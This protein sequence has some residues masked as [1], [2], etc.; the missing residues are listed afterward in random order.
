MNMV[1]GYSAIGND[2]LRRAWYLTDRNWGLLRNTREASLSQ[3]VLCSSLGEVYCNGMAFSVVGLGTSVPN[4][5]FQA[6]SAAIDLWINKD[7]LEILEQLECKTEHSKTLVVSSIIC[8]NSQ[9]CTTPDADLKIQ[10]SEVF[11]NPKEIPISTMPATLEFKCLNPIAKWT[12]FSGS[13]LDRTL[14]SAEVV[15]SGKL[16]RGD[17]CDNQNA[18]IEAV[19]YQALVASK[20]QEI[21]ESYSLR[22]IT[23]NRVVVVN[24]GCFSVS[25]PGIFPQKAPHVVQIEG[26]IGRLFPTLV[27]GFSR[28]MSETTLK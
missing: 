27:S 3:H 20:L 18:A 8:G 26:E 12:L 17:W 2:E 14:W 16:F 21:C 25:Y 13:S 23:E 28:M 9:V 11:E 6:L 5:R 7:R 10:A 22:Q 1:T 4:A 15:S 19:S 24:P